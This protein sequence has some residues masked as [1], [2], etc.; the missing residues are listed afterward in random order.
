MS[1]KMLTTV[2]VTEVDPLAQCLI[3]IVVNLIQ[4]SNTKVIIAPFRKAVNNSQVAIG[5]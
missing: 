1:A 5:I 3:S 4:L 2:S